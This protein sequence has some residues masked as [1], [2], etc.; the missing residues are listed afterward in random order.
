MQEDNDKLSHIDLA[1]LKRMSQKNLYGLM[2]TYDTLNTKFVYG[3]DLTK[4]EAIELI[5]LSKFFMEYGPTEGVKIRARMFYE[6]YV[7]GKLE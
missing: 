7:K 6:K 4:K 3:V 1:R 2:E 5:T